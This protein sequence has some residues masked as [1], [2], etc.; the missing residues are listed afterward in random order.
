MHRLL[1]LVFLAMSGPSAWAFPTYA[2][3]TGFRGAELLTAEERKAH[4]ARLQSMRTN[5]EC[6][7][8]MVAHEE[9]LQSRASAR[10]QVLPP[11]TTGPCEVMRRFGRIR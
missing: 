10:N 2:G 3:G 5:E 7:A 6:E 9:V 8:Y 4:V 11:R 1:L